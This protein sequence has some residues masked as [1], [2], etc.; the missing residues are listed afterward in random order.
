MPSNYRCWTKAFIYTFEQHFINT[1]RI[2]CCWLV[3]LNAR[4]KVSV[5]SNLIEEF[6][7]QVGVRQGSWLDPLLFI[8]GLEALSQEFRTG[9]PWEN[10]YADDLDIINESLDELHKKLIIWK[11][12]IEG[13]GL[14]VNMGKT[15]VLISGPGLDV[16]QK[17]GRD[18]WLWPSRA[19]A[20]TPVAVVVVP[21]ES[22]INALVSLVFWS[23]VL[24]LSINGAG[25]R[26]DQWME[27]QWPRSQWAW[28]S[29]G[30]CYF[31]VT[32][33]TDYPRVVVVKLPG[34]MGQ[35]QWA[36][37]C[38]QLPLISHHLQRKN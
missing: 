21:V 38:S 36:P 20:Q 9:C 16:L 24:V 12:S 25:N 34:R 7:V 32:P 8:T 22:T 31:S 28:R 15:K 37:V 26:P 30:W 17:S 1:Y 14:W 35:I 5:E 6:S 18:P 4:S 3:L 23:R 33:W 27:D 13:K 2:Y 29:L 10:L 11:T 19:S